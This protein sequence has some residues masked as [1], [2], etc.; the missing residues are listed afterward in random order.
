MTVADCKAMLMS[1]PCNRQDEVQLDSGQRTGAR[2]RS[3]ERVASSARRLRPL[4]VVSFED[5]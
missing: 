4:V 5:G 3:A 2:L 1:Q